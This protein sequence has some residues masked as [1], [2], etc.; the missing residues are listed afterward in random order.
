MT[1]TNTS[2][3]VLSTADQVKLAAKLVAEQ[4]RITAR[5]AEIAIALVPLEEVA[6]RVKAEA[7]AR[8]AIDVTGL[9]AMTQVAFEFG[10]KE[11]RKTLTGSVVAFAAAEG[12]V[13]A[14]YKIEVGSGFNTELFT[15]P[16]RDVSLPVNVQ[17]A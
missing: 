11:N 15:V 3:P 1:D 5:L 9:D 6:A 13:P 12:K 14:R 7:E 4:T 16:A 10:R 2:A 8:A 17:A